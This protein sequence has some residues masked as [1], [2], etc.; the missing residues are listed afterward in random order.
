M[1]PNQTCKLLYNKGNHKMK[2][3]PIEWE[4]LVTNDAT[5]KGLIS[6]ICNYS[7]NSATKKPNNP[8]EK[9]AED[10]N[11]IDPSLSAKKTWRTGRHMKR[12]STLLII[13]EMQIK[14]TMSYHLTLVRMAIVN[15]ST[16]N[17]CW[18]GCRKKRALL[19]C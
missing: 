16:N 7:F 17:N 6:N 11:R 12:C 8:T 18:T 10:L 4:K 9:W 5:Y 13:Q 1:G 15:K 2:R 14:T 19:H 3:Q